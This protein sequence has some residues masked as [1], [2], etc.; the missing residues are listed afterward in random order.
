MPA[1]FV[2]LINQKPKA[3]RMSKHVKKIQS[4]LDAEPTPGYVLARVI[5]LERV[6]EAESG[7]SLDEVLDRIEAEEKAA[8]EKA[9][10]EKAAAAKK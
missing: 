10:A 5:R 8:A 3:N 4:K 9:A 6:V 1:R 7:K 2:P